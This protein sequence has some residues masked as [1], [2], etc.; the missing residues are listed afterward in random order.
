MKEIVTSLTQRG[1]VTVPAEVRRLLG[2]KSRDKVAFAID[3]DQV[4]LVP[5][6]FTVESAYGS[7]KPRNRPE[8]FKALSRAAR[9]ERVRRKKGGHG[10]R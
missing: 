7:V 8:D 1:Q 3:N 10:I 5:V 4:R 9:E 6:T 2:L